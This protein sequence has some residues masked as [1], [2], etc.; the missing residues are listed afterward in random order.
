MCELQK[1]IN[2]LALISLA[3]QIIIWKLGSLCKYMYMYKG[4]NE[5]KKERE[6][7]KKINAL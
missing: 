6:K 3:N 7:K 1:K 2:T 5:K 4:K